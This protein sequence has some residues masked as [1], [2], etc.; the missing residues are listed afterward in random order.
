MPSLAY[1]TR[2]VA[3]LSALMTATSLYAAPVLNKS[4][5]EFNAGLHIQEEFNIFADNTVFDPDYPVHELRL[6]LN[7][8]KTYEQV[9]FYDKTYTPYGQAVAYNTL[10][11][12]WVKFKGKLLYFSGESDGTNKVEVIPFRVINPAG[13]VSEPGE[14]RIS[15]DHAFDTNYDVYPADDT[16]QTVSDRAVAI[17]VKANDPNVPYYFGVEIYSNPKHGRVSVNQDY[18][19]T[20]TPSAGYIGQDAF[21]YRIKGNNLYEITSAVAT[22]SVEVKEPNQPPVISG[23]PA[24]TVIV[25]GHYQFVPQVLDPE[26]DPLSFSVKNLPGWARFNTQTGALSGTP[27]GADIG[28]YSNI[29]IS[30]S[31][32][33]NVSVLAPFSIQVNPN[34]ALLNWSPQEVQVG[35]QAKLI[36]DTQV[37]SRCELHFAAGAHI[38]TDMQG[39]ITATAVLA[40]DTLDTRWHC[41][42]HSGRFLGE[43]SAQ[44]AVTRLP[45]PVLRSTR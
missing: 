26:N 3:G 4:I 38:E 12:R 45:A 40:A 13:E 27:A 11:R 16:A 25:N 19:V 24:K 44:L 5:F 28:V 41:F 9:S 36:W 20:Y 31:D 33:H 35:E 39:A 34:V 8:G 10:D 43:F 37:V 6:V 17:N 22:V 15:L 42:N 7:E 2:T 29:E 18:T 32:G 30:V 21:R 23:V 1:F 14:I